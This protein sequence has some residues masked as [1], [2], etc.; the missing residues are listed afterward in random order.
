M[1]DVWFILLPSGQQTWN[2]L[3]SSASTAQSFQNF[4]LADES[5]ELWERAEYETDMIE[6]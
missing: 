6:P 4:P 1:Q 5:Y 2:S 3:D